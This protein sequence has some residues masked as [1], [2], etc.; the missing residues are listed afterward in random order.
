MKHADWTALSGLRRVDYAEITT[1]DY[2]VWTA[3]IDFGEWTTLSG[4]RLVD[5]G[6]W[7]ICRVGITTRWRP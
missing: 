4:P 1:L 3:L 7:T 6:E 5:A 2:A